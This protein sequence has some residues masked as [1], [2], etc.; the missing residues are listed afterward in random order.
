MKNTPE[1]P[2]VAIFAGSSTPQDAK[3]MAA[4]RDLGTKLGLA[5][6]DITYG[7]GMQGVMGEVA[8]AAHA[9][10]AAVTAVVFSKYAHE[11][12]L[13]G[14]TIIPVETEQERFKAMTSH[15][16][17]V[18]FFALPGGPGTM[19]EVMQGLE[20][21]VYDGGPPVILVKAG[22][23]LDGLKASFDTAVAGGLIKPQM[24][25]KLQ[26]WSLE[27]PLPLASSSTAPAPLAAPPAV[28]RP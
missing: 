14:A 22:P 9:A 20:L 24:A 1:R 10:G 26:L 7:G 13:P 16:N 23:Y 3:I 8:R 19:R 4:A 25:G 2:V 27:D 5:G 11:E 15:K 17:P 28:S 6:Y 21:A 18:G 12:Q